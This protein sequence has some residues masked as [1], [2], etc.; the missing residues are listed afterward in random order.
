GGVG[1][2]RSRAVFD[3][4]GMVVPSL[5]MDAAMRKDQGTIFVFDTRSRAAR[6]LRDHPGPVL[7]LAFAP[8]RDGQPA[9]QPPPLV[10]AAL[11]FVEK[12]GRHA[13]ALW[14]WDDLDKRTH[15]EWPGALPVPASMRPGLA[16]WQ[17][18]GKQGLS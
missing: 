5:V 15:R 6:V 9:D 11:H 8:P 10:S 4:R 2:I 18:P 14:V 7:A 13:G 1:V 3:E 12:E 16:A 17:G